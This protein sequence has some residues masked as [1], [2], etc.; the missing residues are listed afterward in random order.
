M[1]APV[2]ARVDLAALLR[3]SDVTGVMDQLDAELIG[4]LP[5]KRR[6][7]EIA[8]YLLVTKARKQLG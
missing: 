8:A 2:E 7:R 3:E 6:I 1:T 5:V 4:L